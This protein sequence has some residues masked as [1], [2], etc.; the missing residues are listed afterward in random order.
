M[1]SLSTIDH[2]IPVVAQQI[3]TVRMAAYKQEAQLLGLTRLPPLERR[4]DDIISSSE[5]FIGASETGILARV[6]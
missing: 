5:E 3:H 2:R 1:P 4:L 6:L